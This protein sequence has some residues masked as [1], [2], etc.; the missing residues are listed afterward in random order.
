MVN[1]QTLIDLA[2]LVISFYFL[3]GGVFNQDW[4]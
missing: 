2:I 3:A 1:Q 4:C